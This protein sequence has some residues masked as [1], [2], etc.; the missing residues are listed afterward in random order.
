[1]GDVSGGRNLYDA[2][3]VYDV[4][5]AELFSRAV[6]RQSE[7]GSLGADIIDSVS[8]TQII[9]SILRQHADAQK[10]E[11]HSR[12]VADYNGKLS[13][14]GKQYDLSMAMYMSHIEDVGISVPSK[15]SEI[16]HVPV[17]IKYLDDPRIAQI[18]L[19]ALRNMSGARLRRELRP[20]VGGLDKL[21]LAENA[22]TIAKLKA[23]IARGIYDARTAPF[24]S[25]AA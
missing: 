24:L 11:W 23:E 8:A 17:D 6:V 16:I 21:I 2:R 7:T 1:M 13:I 9:E 4:I 5:A 3:R 15:S 25:D 14:K 20:S 19:L 22:G 18:M 12:R 10:Q